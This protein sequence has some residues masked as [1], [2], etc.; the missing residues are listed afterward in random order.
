MMRTSSK[1]NKDPNPGEW[2]F[3]RPLPRLS[4]HSVRRRTRTLKAQ[5]RRSLQLLGTALVSSKDSRSTI[6]IA[7]MCPFAHSCKSATPRPAVVTESSCLRM[8]PEQLRPIRGTLSEHALD[9]L[10]LMREIGERIS[11]ATAIVLD[12]FRPEGPSSS[13]N[14]KSPNLPPYA[15]KSEKRKTRKG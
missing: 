7:Y 13:L 11:P 4:E 8:A 9:T 6:C 12:Q 3:K 10:A 2:D 15:W 5:A 1:Q 14:Q